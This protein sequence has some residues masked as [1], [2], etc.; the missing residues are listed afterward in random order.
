MREVFDQPRR[1]FLWLQHEIDKA[2]RNRAVHHARVLGLGLCQRQSAMLLDRPQPARS[3]AA[4]S[5]QDDACGMDA[6]ILRKRGEEP[7]DDRAMSRSPSQ[8]QL[9]VVDRQLYARGNDMDGSGCHQ[10]AVLGGN[11]GQ[12][13]E[14][15][16]D[17]NQRTF[18]IG[19]QVHDH[20][21]AQRP[22]S[23]ERG[24]EP[25]KRLQSASRGAY[26]YD[27][28]LLGTLGIHHVPSPLLSKSEGI[29]AAPLSIMPRMISASRP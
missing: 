6:L 16:K 25:L 24:E 8:A 20:H 28:R 3:I 7:I 10:R 19:R 18:A 1:H 9:A 4:R 26:P 5:R 13:R 17:L 14:A 21:E 2:R 22:L 11:D 29:G 12:G 15:L 23:A 27:G